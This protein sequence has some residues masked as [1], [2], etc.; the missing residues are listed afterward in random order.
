MTKEEFEKAMMEK[1]K[2]TKDF[3][4]ILDEAKEKLKNEEWR[5][6]PAKFVFGGRL[7]NFWE[8]LEYLK[9]KEKRKKEED[10]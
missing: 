4:S 7:M 1:P 9:N 6:G 5:E 10:G 8:A 3:L 2:V